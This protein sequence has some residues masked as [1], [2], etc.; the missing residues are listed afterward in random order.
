M[1]I[2]DWSSDVCSSDLDSVLSLRRAAQVEGGDVH[3]GGAQRGAQRADETGLVLVGDVEHVRRQGSLD[4]DA[5]DID[6]AGLGA[7][8]QG[9]GDAAR[10]AIAVHG[11]ADERLVVAV[12]DRK[13]VV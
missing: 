9:A 10:P 4:G 5:P 13:S 12:A 2:S 6:H 8:K 7:A 11:E 1:R 3:A